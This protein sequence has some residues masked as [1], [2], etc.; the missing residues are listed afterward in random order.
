MNMIFADLILHPASVAVWI[1]VG[2][3]TGWLA[4]KVME[5]PSYGITGD[6]LVGSI[7]AVVGGALVGFFV[8]GDPAFG[9]AV[10]TALM[11]AIV[12]VIGGRL[13]V[14]RLSA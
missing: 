4:A 14:A 7:G 10:L 9:V 6:L 3:I 11:G 1:V 8:D 5:N 12:A 2:M 13:V